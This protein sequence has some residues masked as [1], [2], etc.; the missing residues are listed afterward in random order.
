VLFRSR[1]HLDGSDLTAAAREAQVQI[2]QLEQQI[3]SLKALIKAQKSLVEKQQKVVKHLL[4]MLWPQLNNPYNNDF[5]VLV[6]GEEQKKIE[7]WFAASKEYEHLVE[8]QDLY[9]QQENDLL[10]LRR[11]QAAFLRLKRMVYIDRLQAQ[12]ARFGSREERQTYQNL[13]QCEAWVPPM[14]RNITH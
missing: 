9:Q 6:S 4:L 3:K 8:S 12:L 7:A 5:L 1:L 2:L 11:E 10:T 14:G 13:Q